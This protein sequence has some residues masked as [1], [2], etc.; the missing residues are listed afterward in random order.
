MSEIKMILLG[1]SGVGKTTLAN[2]WIYQSTIDVEPTIGAQNMIKYVTV[3][4][5][6]VKVILW[7]TAGQEQYRSITPLYIRGARIA[8][9]V[10]SVCDPQSFIDLPIWLNL[11]GESECPIPAILAINKTDIADHPDITDYVNQ[12][13]NSFLGVFYISAYTGENVEMLFNDAVLLV[14]GPETVQNNNIS[15]SV[16]TQA[17]AQC[18]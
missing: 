12:F 5:K 18:C 11:L 2:Y 7:D 13:R 4:D 3:Q 17:R 16:E 8:I 9:I 14:K 10:A 6:T 1:N 15:I